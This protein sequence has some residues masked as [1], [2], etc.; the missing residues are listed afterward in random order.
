MRIQTRAR[1]VRK[2]LRGMTL[3]EVAISTAIIGTTLV[4]TTGSF[5]S[6]ISATSH[7]KHQSEAM[8]FMQTVMEDLSAQPFANLAAFNGDRVFNNG[9]EARS[10]MVADITVFAAAAGL[11]QVTVVVRD[12]NIGTEYG[13]VATLRADR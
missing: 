8:V 11:Q 1:Q 7:A 4:A 12:L 6:S 2:Y 5:L 13:R 10:R 3:T 9:T